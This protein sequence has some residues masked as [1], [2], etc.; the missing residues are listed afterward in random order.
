MAT[1]T[2]GRLAVCVFAK[3]P[4]AGHA[5]TRLAAGLGGDVAARLARAFLR[6]TWSLVRSLDW[7]VPILATTDVHDPFWTELAGAEVWSQGD[8]DLGT[9]MTRILNRA[10]EHAPVALLIGSDAPGVPLSA[11][12]QA[13]AALRFA[14]VVIGPAADGG[15]YLI[16][17]REPFPTGA[18][19]GILW[20]TAE[21]RIE[22]ERRLR[23]LR[24]SV[25][26]VTPWF[27]V[28][29]VE[30]L[31]RLR[32]LG[33]RLARTAPE[34]ARV[35]EDIPRLEADASLPEGA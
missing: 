12:S 29:E 35:L 6:D 26:E 14:D 32:H 3:P 24:R 8:G 23:S 2:D 33:E 27:D 22:T 9:R 17:C 20:S 15:F 7:A 31:E 28:D 1:V 25:V 10:L 30:D 18:L 4:R 16:G 13:R 5:K 19:D 34:T 11:L 21:T